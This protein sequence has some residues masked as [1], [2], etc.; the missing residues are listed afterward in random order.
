MPTPCLSLPALTCPFTCI[1][2]FFV[3]VS[4]EL[5]EVNARAYVTLKLTASWLA[6]RL[7]MLSILI[8][9]GT[10]VWGAV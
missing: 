10:G 2:P 4:D 8:I 6:M 1:L 3:Q 5:M 7:D 9:A